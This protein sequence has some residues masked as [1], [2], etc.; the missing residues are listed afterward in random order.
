MSK[1]CQ[2]MK[3]EHRRLMKAVSDLGHATRAQGPCNSGN[4]MPM[5][6]SV[7]LSSTEFY[8]ALGRKGIRISLLIV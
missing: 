7:Y 5:P 4:V 6:Y 3:S 1:S 2:V 8:R